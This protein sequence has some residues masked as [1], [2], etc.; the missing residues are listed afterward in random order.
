MEARETDWS[1]ECY[2]GRWGIRN[3]RPKDIHPLRW[4]DGEWVVE[5]VIFIY[6]D[7]SAASTAC[8]T[9]TSDT[10]GGKGDNFISSSHEAKDRMA[11]KLD[12]LMTRRPSWPHCWLAIIWT[13]SLSAV[14]VVVCFVVISS[15]ISSSRGWKTKM[16]RG[17]L[18][19]GDVILRLPHSSLFFPSSFMWI[20]C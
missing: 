12:Y 20:R 10:R 6:C 2:F 11:N 4:W 15:S 7:C 17:T 5:N 16:K 18:S 8:T 1:L 19:Q 3:R 13:V 9:T 14:R